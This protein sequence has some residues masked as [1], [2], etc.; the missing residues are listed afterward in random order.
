VSIST[1]ALRE[2]QVVRF[3]TD[4]SSV[5]L[6]A[7]LEE[8]VWQQKNYPG[9]QS[10]AKYRPQS[11]IFAAFGGN[12]CLGITRMFGG[13][14]RTPPFLEE[15]AFYDAATRARLLSG[16][17]CGVVEELGTTAVAEGARAHQTSIAMWRAAFRDA[18]G[19]GVLEWG[20]IMEPE[21][22]L[23]LPFPAT[24]SSHR[25]SRRD[26]RCAPHVVRGHPYLHAREEAG[27]LPLVRPCAAVDMSLLPALP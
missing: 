23:R 9:L 7:A 21:Q 25:L 4:A 5:A 20:I 19:R 11:R 16:C 13:S 15:M 1:T 2:S 26:V 8:S 18:V 17:A 14:P 27:L 6:A 12:E 22:A 10:Y 24:R 3:V